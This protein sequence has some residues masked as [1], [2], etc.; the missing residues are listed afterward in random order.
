MNTK[1][2]MVGLLLALPMHVTPTLAAPPNRPD[3]PAISP[4]S[5]EK[6]RS[7]AA[8]AER[9]AR[10]QGFA[11]VISIV[12]N[13]GN[14]KHF[15][16]MDGTSSGSIQVAQLKAATSARFPLSSRTLGERSAGLPANPYASLPGF[17]LLEGGLPIMDA[18]GRHIGGIG[19]SGATPELDAQFAK[20][21]L[22]ES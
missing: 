18:N 2:F 14:L 3:T 22:E 20:A 13:H 16:R 9:A 8:A 10:A 17:T 5:A 15:H 6:A 21:A 7:L 12:D 11:I 4:I 1:H 19:I